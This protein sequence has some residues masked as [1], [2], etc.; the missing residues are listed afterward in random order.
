MSIMTAPSIAD[1]NKMSGKRSRVRYRCRACRRAGLTNPWFTVRRRVQYPKCPRCRSV[2]VHRQQEV[3]QK[4]ERKRRHL[5][6]YA[7]GCRVPHPHRYGTHK[8][9]RGYSGVVSDE[10]LQDIEMRLY[11]NYPNRS[12]HA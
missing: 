2:D 12:Q 8:L 11:N 1:S 4:A 7:V 10:E 9:C 3:Q 5:Y 6:C